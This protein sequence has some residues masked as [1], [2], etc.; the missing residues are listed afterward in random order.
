MFLEKKFLKL[1]IGVIIWGLLPLNT[2]AGVIFTSE[3]DK[4][5]ASSFTLD[6][7]DV[8]ADFIDLNFGT[9][10]SAKLRFD[11]PNNKFIL[12][13]HL[14]LSN[15]ELKN[16][17]IENATTAPACDGTVAGKIYHNTT[18]N[19]SYICSNS[20]WEKINNQID[21]KLE[22]LD[23]DTK[24][25]IEES[26]DEDIIRFDTA[27]SE[28]M[29]IENDGEVNI[30]GTLLR[31]NRGKGNVTDGSDISFDAQ[32][33]IAS[34]SN[35]LFN[36]DSNNSSTTERFAWNKD[37]DSM[38]GATEI[39]T[40]TEDG[41]LDVSDQLA[42]G[43]NASITNN[44]TMRIS[45]Y[46]NKDASTYQLISAATI[47]SPTLTV[48]R[49]SYGG[50]FALTNNKTEDIAGGFDSDAT[51][52]YGFTQTT[53]TNTFRTNRGGQFEARNSSTATS[54]LGSVYGVLGIG[55]Q[56]SSNDSSDINT[57]M[58]VQAQAVGYTGASST[59][60]DIT[61]AYGVY[62]T[63]YPYKSDII[64]AQGV[65]G[66]VST[67]D[68]YSGNITTAYGTRGQVRSNSTSG[69]NITNGYGGYFSTSKKV[70]APNMVQTNAIYAN[71]VGG[72][73]NYAGRFFTNSSDGSTNEAIYIDAKN[74]SS[75]NYGILGVDGDWV[76]DANG[77]GLAGG[78]GPGGDL[79]L[80]ETAELKL[81][82]DG[83]NAQI[84]T[85]SGDLYV[86]GT[87]SSNDVVLSRNGG[88]VAIGKDNPAYELDIESVGTA[89]LR[90]RGDDTGYTNAGVILEATQSANARGLGIFMH[91]DPAD[92]EWYM[93][94]PYAGND[95]FVI[96]RKGSVTGH[97]ESTADDATNNLLTLDS[98]GNMGIGEPN[99]TSKLQVIG[100]PSYADNSAALS[101]GL[102]IGAFYRTG[103]LLKVVH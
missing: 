80:G 91:D 66:Y 16:S 40:L 59:A 82:F 30:G 6:A 100:L 17:R 8:S 87:T 50:N 60:G 83:S 68:N 43:K 93:G 13:H 19:N 44:Q 46:Y 28:R 99:P 75:N 29:K 84:S 1:Y 86:G 77:D 51:A 21:S 3:D 101:G 18:D 69:G 71:A 52:V 10:N 90:L 102:S 49:T 26:N 67:N 88:G 76:L 73:T 95:R 89:S 96:N 79:V 63:A 54:N 33:L 14:D 81:Y 38:T 58:G 103:D 27:G 48:D 11:I 12:N 92:N 97:D 23:N 2:F 65:Y 94:R 72:D 85:K 22:D 45:E 7:G 62:G 37:S 25:Q 36:I 5:N 70:G 39:M 4:T 61:N 98:N 41:D 34:E 42:V 74:A 9:S 32:G 15:N 24:I 78:T 35:M 55:R 20:V 64:S 47:T 57:A 31:F 56:Y 53:G